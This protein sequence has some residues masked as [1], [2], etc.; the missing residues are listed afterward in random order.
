M[1]TLS[2]MPRE[3]SQPPDH[4]VSRKAFMQNKSLNILIAPVSYPSPIAMP[5]LYYSNLPGR[6]VSPSEMNGRGDRFQF[7]DHHSTYNPI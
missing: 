1:A 6:C 2:G 7:P 4:E 5:L 3:K